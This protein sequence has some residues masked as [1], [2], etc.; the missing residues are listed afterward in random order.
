MKKGTQESDVFDSLKTET[1]KPLIIF[2]SIRDVQRS[3]WPRLF[4]QYI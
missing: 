3:F 4:T 1:D 2:G